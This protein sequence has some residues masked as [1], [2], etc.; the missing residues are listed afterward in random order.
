MDNPQRK[1]LECKIKNL[2][3]QLIFVKRIFILSPE[4][5]EIFIW[6]ININKTEKWSTNTAV[7]DGLGFDS[8]NLYQQGWTFFDYKNAR[9]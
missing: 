6:N 4:V 8:S 3:Q 9:N 7:Y 1:K 5:L 2:K